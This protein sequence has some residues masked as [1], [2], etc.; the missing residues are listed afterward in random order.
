L[1]KLDQRRPALAKITPDNRPLTRTKS[2]EVKSQSGKHPSRTP[3]LRLH[4]PC[5]LLYGAIARGG[6]C[7]GGEPPVTGNCLA[8]GET[9]DIERL[10][11]Y[12]EWKM[13]AKSL[14]VA[15]FLVAA[16]TAAAFAPSS[17][18]WWDPSESGRGYVIDVQDGVMTV[19]AYAYDGS[20]ESLWY[21]GAAPYNNSTN[22]FTAQMNTFSGGQCFGCGPSSP[23][24]SPAGTFQIVFTD[25]ETATLHYPGGSSH[26]EHFVYG[27]A[28]KQDY[29]LGLWSFSENAGNGLISAQWINFDSHYVGSDGSL[30]VSGQG[31]NS[32]SSV[33]LGQYLPSL[34]EFIVVIIDDVHYSHS[35]TLAG[36]DRRMLGVGETEP[37]NVNPTG[38]GSVASASRLLY[39]SELT[40]NKKMSR[41]V[42]GRGP[43]S[44]ALREAEA[45]LR[46]A[47]AS[48]APLT[49][50]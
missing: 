48:A 29:L 50:E 6:S 28:S 4:A 44:D 33:A 7:T 41:L 24:A 21:L 49:M 13:K 30:Y 26:L 32:S 16:R 19:S 12:G 37:P 43:S 45:A 2:G 36:D 14:L 9:S 3:S 34:G 10:Q 25:L 22:T 23:L 35:Y 31:D 38:N 47:V 27:F 20:G 5:I 18:L 42:T 8:A 40:S 46:L 17:G 15:A 11:N 1:R 39:S